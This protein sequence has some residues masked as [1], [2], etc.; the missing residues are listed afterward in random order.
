MPAP[1]QIHVDYSGEF[2]V[3]FTDDGVPVDLS[4][5]EQIAMEVFDTPGSPLG[6]FDTTS[7]PGNFDTTGL[8]QGELVFRW[9]SATFDN[10]TYL[11]TAVTA[12]HSLRFAIETDDWPAPGRI[13]PTYL[14]ATFSE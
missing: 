5:A 12:Q 10:T 3:V 8:A 1:I 2:T 9:T 4:G 14:V 11:G 13:V 6:S 7:H